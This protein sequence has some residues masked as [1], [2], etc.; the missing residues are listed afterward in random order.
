[1]Q[2]QLAVPRT[3]PRAATPATFAGPLPVRVGRRAKGKNLGVVPPSS[4]GGPTRLAEPRLVPEPWRTAWIT[5]FTATDRKRSVGFSSVRNLWYTAE[6]R[7][8]P[9]SLQSVW[10]RTVGSLRFSPLFYQPHAWIGIVVVKAVERDLGPTPG[11]ADGGGQ[12]DAADGADGTDDGAV[13]PDPLGDYCSTPT[14]YELHGAFK[15]NLVGW[16]VACEIQPGKSAFYKRN[17]TRVTELDAGEF[18]HE[19]FPGGF[20]CCEG[21]QGAGAGPSYGH[22]DVCVEMCRFAFC[23]EMKA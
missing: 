10:R 20:A 19:T 5:A 1:M 6:W 13:Q 12:G 9:R 16:R 4:F 21:C 15:E 23:S 8:R 14:P 22:P 7:R 18:L 17:Q 3:V 11:G 2:T